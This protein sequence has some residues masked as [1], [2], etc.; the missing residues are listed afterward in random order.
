MQG[1]EP[2]GRPANHSWGAESGAGLESE[3][4][5]TETERRNG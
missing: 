3:P 4:T 2:A 5:T 1:C